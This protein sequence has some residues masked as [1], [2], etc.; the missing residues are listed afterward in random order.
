MFK[1]QFPPTAA[2]TFFGPARLHV[3]TAANTQNAECR[4]LIRRDN[5][6]TINRGEGSS[7]AKGRWV[8]H[9]RPGREAQGPDTGEILGHKEVNAGK[10]QSNQVNF[11]MSPA[12]ILKDSGIDKGAILRTSKS[13]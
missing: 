13:Q 9:L 12:K 11:K 6:I 8:Q 7:M 1:V 5:I 3:Q 2:S 10:A 4:A